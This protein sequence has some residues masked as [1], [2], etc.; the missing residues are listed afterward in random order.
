MTLIKL[1]YTNQLKSLAKQ[2]HDKLIINQ[3]SSSS[4]LNIEETLLY[5]K[6][7]RLAAE[8]RPSIAELE[9][10]YMIDP[11]EYGALLNEFF[12]TWFQVRNQLLHTRIKAEIARIQITHEQVPDLISLSTTG[13]NYLRS[14]CTAEWNLFK[15]FF[16]RT[17]EEELLSYLDSLSDYLY[18]L[19]RPQILHEQKLDVLCDLA[20]IANALI[21]MDNSLVDEPEDLQDSPP[22][23]FKFSSLLKPILQD[24]QTRLIFRAQAIIQ[25]EVAHYQPKREDLDYPNKLI[26]VFQ[27]RRQA[28]DHKLK[29][30]PSVTQAQSTLAVPSTVYQSDTALKSRLPPAET[31]ETWYPTL[32]KTLWVLS[33]LHTYVN[34]SI[35]EDFAG[36]AVGICSESIIKASHLIN[37]HNHQTEPPA[38]SSATT[39]P[40]TTTMNSNSLIDGELFAIRHLLILKEMIRTLDVVQVERAVDLGPITDVLKE[41]LNPSLKDSL[42]FKPITL[43]NRL[44]NL[45][46]QQDL[47]R[48]MKSSLTSGPAIRHK[49]DSALLLLNNIDQAPDQITKTI[50]NK[51]ELDFKLK[52]ICHEFIVHS[53]SLICS[54]SIESFLKKCQNFLHVEASIRSTSDAKNESGVASTTVSST[55]KATGNTTGRLNR[56]LINQEWASK[57]VIL[58]I[59]RAFLNDLQL[60]LRIIF[61]RVS[62]YFHDDD[63]DHLNFNLINV[64][65]PS[66][67]EEIMDRYQKFYNLIKFE[68]DLNNLTV[69]DNGG[70]QE[71]LQDP[72]PDSELDRSGALGIRLEDLNDPSHL[73]KVLSP[74]QIRQL[75][76]L[77]VY[78]QSHHDP[79]VPSSSCS[80]ACSWTE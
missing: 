33:R 15:L 42:I 70:D 71:I 57:D 3:R 17:G 53:C 2:V 36:E 48:R 58:N 12:S 19:L 25:A 7:E 68:F 40:I 49:E 29:K 45:N 27:D 51:S 41:I 74:A 8:L 72:A 79:W 4:N 44:K 47:S 67:Q 9:K 54:N 23:T 76:Q 22:S 26:K 32:R 75:I 56:N 64:L 1:H 6:F 73:Q 21:A 78:N 55:N 5:D 37:S 46:N 61:N 62:L 34:D 11:D 30:N 77:I 69:D 52:S 18:D 14:V 16:P 60:G 63:D 66:L 24:I 10:R 20:T 65:F 59:F 43:L 13:C 80:T 39:N 50:D 31:Q 28:T 35:F 38:A